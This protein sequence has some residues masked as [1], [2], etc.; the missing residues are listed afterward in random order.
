MPSAK[1]MKEPAV[2]AAQER[3]AFPDGDP[4]VQGAGVPKSHLE[5]MEEHEELHDAMSPVYDQLSIAPHWWALEFWPIKTRF[6][7]KSDRWVESYG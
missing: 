7:D 2:E 3:H 4:A 1:T 6:Q 5:G